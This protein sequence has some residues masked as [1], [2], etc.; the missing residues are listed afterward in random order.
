MIVLK[1]WK[2][3]TIVIW[4]RVHLTIPL[5]HSSSITQNH[6]TFLLFGIEFP[7]LLEP[8]SRSNL[9]TISHPSFSFFRPPI[10]LHH[11]HTLWPK[12]PHP[13]LF[14][15]SVL[16]KARDNARILTHFQ[17]CIN[18]ISY[19]NI[20]SWAHP[21]WIETFCPPIDQTHQENCQKYHPENIARIGYIFK[22]LAEW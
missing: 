19:F 7:T 3:K 5:N 2:K 8:N 17:D 22:K 6:Q 20:Y 14:Y 1:V 15:G 21:P 9:N 13:S 12:S 11:H 18:L 4:Y 10:L 16:I